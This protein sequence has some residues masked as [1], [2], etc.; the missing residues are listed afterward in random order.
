MRGKQFEGMLFS[1]FKE[2]AKDLYPFC[3]IMFGGS[4]NILI[5]TGMYSGGRGKCSLAEIIINTELYLDDSNY[6]KD[7]EERII[8]KD[9]L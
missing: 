3:E 8:C 7:G 1:E 5:Q 2:K 9:K 6:E 4:G